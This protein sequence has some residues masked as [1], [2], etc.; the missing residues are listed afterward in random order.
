M[1]PYNLNGKVDLSRPLTEGYIK[2][3]Y[4]DIFEGLGRFP[5]EPYRLKLKPDSTP[6]KHR[7]RKVPVHLEEAFHE[8]INRLCKIDVLEPVKEHTDWVNSYVIVEKDV[9]I[10]SSN[11]HS[12]GHSIKKKLRIC[13]DPKDLNEALEREPYYSRTVDELIAKFHR[14]QFFTIVD[15]DKGYWQVILHPDS[16]KYTCMALDIGRFQWKRLPMGTIV[17]SDVFQRKL[18]SIY[19]GLPGITGIADDMIVYGADEKEHDQNLIRFL[20]VTRNNGLRLNK[21]KLQFKKKEVSFF[22]HRWSAD[23]ISPDP[24]KIESILQMEFP[25]D[26]ETMHSFLGLVNF[27]NRYSPRL[28]EL[29][30]PLRSLILK[31]AHYKILQEHRRAFMDIKSEFR[32]RITLPYFD[33]DK[34]TILQTD[35]S[36]KGF[37]AVILQDDK[38]VYFASRS[39]TP[40]ER[41]YQ[42]LE[43]EC[44]AAIWGMEKFH[45]FLYGKEFL[46][47]T[48]QKPLTAIFKKHLI[49][50]SPRIQRIAIR[51]WTYI[52][53]TEWIK[54]KDNQVAN[55]LSRVTPTP[56]ENLGSRID[57]P[58]LQVNILSAS[59]EQE[60][61]REL[62]RETE[63][64]EEL[65]LVMKTISNGWPT[66]R[67]QTSSTLHPYWNFR[68]ELCIENGILFKN[69][70]II[71]P[72]TLQRKYLDK[73]HNGHQGIQRSLQKAREYVFWTNYT[74]DI[75][76]TIEKCSICQENSTA[77]KTE[78]FKYV[79]TIPPHPWHTLGTDLFYFKKQDFIVLIDYF[80]K[81]LIVRK[82]HNS[83]SSAVIKELGLI[84]SEFGTPF[85]L[86]SDNGPCY[87]SSEFQFFLKEWEI[88][89]ITSSPYYHQSNGLAESMVKTSKALIEKAI[90]QH[91]PWFW[92]LNE[93]RVTPLSDTIPSPAEI[94]FGRRCRSN[95]S[96]LPSQ[97]MNPRISKQREEIARKKLSPNWIG[98][99]PRS[100]TTNMAS[101]SKDEEMDL[102]KDS[103]TIGG[104][105]FI[106]DSGFRRY[107]LQEKQELDQA[108]A[109]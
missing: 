55:G 96:L 83:T 92:L 8:E 30:S 73:I 75:K 85:I 70:K 78:K 27:L 52:F 79:S 82:L 103:P 33:R 93:H 6:A 46:L 36:K 12:P 1:P 10:D 101:G 102:R 49:D 32:N 19:I 45:F 66:Q 14:A 3:E 28:A 90:Q 9:Q 22:G 80:S 99:G 60:E 53:T 77:L 69:T 24:K 11:A 63:L 68:D 42:N 104:T 56:L 16:R 59:M 86:R 76:E 44:M 31:D 25:E 87:T 105:S 35:A 37:G 67:S 62:Q 40:A 58:I 94:L 71:I 64:D 39:L 17:A 81:F 57:L 107:L 100:W 23:G 51:A 21:D 38:P 47:Q 34:R 43:R 13:L 89:L 65:Q 48:D 72:K 41:N 5:G 54:G 98:T 26:K 109:N 15:L 84:F 2:S 4:S 106:H 7:P 29:C 88:Q 18:D 20:D 74:R 91:K 108:K 61:I 97:L 50:V 95:L